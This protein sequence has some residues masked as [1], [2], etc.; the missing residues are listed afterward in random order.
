MKQLVAILKVE[1]NSI[2]VSERILAGF[3]FYRQNSVFWTGYRK[4]S[5]IFIFPS[6]VSILETD[7]VQT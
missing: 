4:Y 1:Q 5:Y 3:G 6:I 7:K 2:S